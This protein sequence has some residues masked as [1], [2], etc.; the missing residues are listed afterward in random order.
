MTQYQ[1]AE[2]ISEY[3]DQTHRGRS[4]WNK[5]TSSAII[6]RFEDIYGLQAAIMLETRVRQSWHD[7]TSVYNAVLTL[8]KENSKWTK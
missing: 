7:K 3:V 4:Q 8:L 1:I 2:Q 5:H 6:S